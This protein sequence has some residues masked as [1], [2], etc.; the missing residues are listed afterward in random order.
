MWWIQTGR[1][2]GGVPGDQEESREG[3]ERP[4]P[5]K[6]KF[7]S[8]KE[9]SRYVLDIRM[10]ACQI[11]LPCVQEVV[12]PIYIVTHYINWGNYF[13]DTQ[14]LLLICL[15]VSRKHKGLPLFLGNCS[16]YIL[17]HLWIWCNFEGFIDKHKQKQ[18]FCAFYKTLSAG[19]CRG[20]HSGEE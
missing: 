8:Y 7:Y 18:A 3:E 10:Q 5:H 2:R 1:A 14:C 20:F 6:R 16:I 17:Y 9:R 19:A 4:R 12:T 15:F 11:E 13:L